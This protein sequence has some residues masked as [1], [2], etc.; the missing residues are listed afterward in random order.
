MR[1]IGLSD[2]SRDR[3]ASFSL[4]VLRTEALRLTALALLALALLLDLISVDANLVPTQ[5]FLLAVVL[6]VVGALTYKTVGVG[7]LL[8]TT[9]LVAGLS[10]TLTIAILL[11]PSSPLACLL[12][13]VVIFASAFGGWRAG[14][15]AAI[16]LSAIVA[17]LGILPDRPVRSDVALVAHLMIWVSLLASWLVSRPL[18]TALDWSWHSY[19]QALDNSEAARVRQAELGRV[20]KSLNETMDRLEQLN[21]ELEWARKAA[22]D[23]RRLKAE[24]ASAVSHELRTPLNLIVGFSEM[25]VLSPAQ[26][27]GEPLPES[28][29]GDVEAI[30]RNACHI[31]TLIDDI[32]DLSQIDAERMG[33]QKQRVAPLAIVNEAVAITAPRF[34]SQGL[35]LDVDLPTDLPSVEADPV[36]IRQ[37][38]VNLLINAT[39]F[40]D[41]GGATI[42]AWHDGREVTVVVAD[43]GVGIA[44]DDLPHVFAEFRQSGQ[45]ERQ[46]GGS[47]LGLAV[48]KRF[49]E[50]HGGSMW[51]E[52]QLGHGTTFFFTLPVS[53][54][55]VT[56][57][58]ASL[59][60]ATVR[61]PDDGEPSRL[62]VVVDEQGE[63]AR[64]FQR[65]LD[66]YA[67]VRAESVGQAARVLR[68]QPAD[69]VL[70]TSAE[71][72][73]K[74][75][76]LQAT[77]PELQRLPTLLCPLRTIRSTAAV[78]GARDYLVKPVT[79]EKLRAAIRSVGRRVR[80]VLV[81]DDD[82]EM[83]R[84]LERMIHVCVRG[85]R[86]VTARDGVECLELVRRERPDLVLL[87]LLMP[88]LD[89]Y[90]ALERLRT[91]EVTRD[92]PVIV[93]TA[94]G[95]QDETIRASSVTVTCTDGLSVGEAVRC[96]RSSLDALSR[97]ASVIPPRPPA[98]S[99]A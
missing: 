58:Y 29:S 40:A 43:T 66:G 83:L 34:A 93:V 39:R 9:V 5:G 48:S 97:Q 76:T 87:D 24:F 47:G 41:E 51:A 82:P 91:D 84:L 55:V 70:L 92:V 38:L 85:S 94:T 60:P 2:L 75:Q 49:V 3:Y 80:S 15:L 23:A 86:V 62:V 27:Y 4:E 53:G 26:S 52:S 50:L 56:K 30:Y 72:L 12:S 44:A 46:R 71:T 25:M 32:L 45:P 28:Y 88:E 79:Y 81:T 18:Q 68:D 67:V 31:A 42:R 77:S 21:R 6:A 1:T 20:T 74:W 35:S 33:L 11:F 69:G 14:L 99:P 19:L 73:R 7:P 59:P 10:V 8:G 90:G 78:L 95:P 54:S 61:L 65:Y 89:G 57:P 37:V 64:V 96:L 13:V 16:G 63:A 22:D 98:G 36:R 17:V